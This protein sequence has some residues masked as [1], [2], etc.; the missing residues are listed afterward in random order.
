MILRETVKQKN[1]WYIKQV[2]CL[3]Y[4]LY[5]SKLSLGLNVT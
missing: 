5:L 2:N 1:K 3:I 4:H